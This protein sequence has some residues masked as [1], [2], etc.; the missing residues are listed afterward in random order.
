MRRKYIDAIPFQGH[1]T[2]LHSLHI[3]P[4][5][6]DRAMEGSNSSVIN[7]WIK[8]NTEAKLTQW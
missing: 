8:V 7:A 2:S 5:R 1:M 4:D 3:E 6:R